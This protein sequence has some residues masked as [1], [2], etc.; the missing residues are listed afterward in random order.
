MGVV[1]T[2]PHIPANLERNVHQYREKYGYLY[3]NRH[4]SVPVC[5]RICVC[6]VGAYGDVDT[7]ISYP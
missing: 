2:L 6:P 7:G 3:I 5:K 4:C 1:H